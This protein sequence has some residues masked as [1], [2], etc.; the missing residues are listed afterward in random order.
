M[1][2]LNTM[3]LASGASHNKNDSCQL[4]NDSCAFRPYIDFAIH[5]PVTE[6][7]RCLSGSVALIR[8]PLFLALFTRDGCRV[9]DPKSL[10]TPALSG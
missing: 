5:N 3:R 4:V 7:D 1:D 8:S 2:R 10:P 6:T 9:T